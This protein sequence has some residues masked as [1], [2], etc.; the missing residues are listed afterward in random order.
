M[1]EAWQWPVVSEREG[2][3]GDGGTGD[4]RQFRA[5][6]WDV[7]GV[8]VELE[9]IREGYA[10]FVTAL[11]EQH[12]LDPGRALERWQDRLGEYFRAREGTEYGSAYEGYRLATESLFEDPPAE[13]AWRPLL[14]RQARDA[15]R[16][17]PG[18]VEVLTAL[19]DAGVYLGIV[20]DV[21]DRELDRMLGTFGLAGRFD[22]VTT[23]EAVG[24]R[25]P[26]P[27]MFADATEKL[28][29]ADI[30]PDEALMVGD[31]YRHDVAGAREAGLV[32]VG[33]RADAHGEAAA[34]EITDLRE[35]LVVV[36]LETDY[37]AEG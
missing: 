24:H 26:D 15:L 11:A 18:V 25:K 37:V 3:D 32:P 29:E 19:D 36:G 28:R 31:R 21:D 2:D 7:G 10:G 34:Y 20:S 23:S 6:L 9:S 13:T 16:T 33:Y 30:D 14:E 12:D 4:E 5:V 22:A 27:R 1:P 8:L 35:L 17:E